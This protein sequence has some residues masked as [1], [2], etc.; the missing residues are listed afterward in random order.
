M[1]DPRLQRWVQEGEVEEWRARN[2]W[3]I[4]M[5]PHVHSKEQLVEILAKSPYLLL[6]STAM[7]TFIYAFQDYE[8]WKNFY[9]EPEEF[10][11][12]ITCC[13]D[14]VETQ[15]QFRNFLGIL[16]FSPSWLQSVTH[17]RLVLGDCDEEEDVESPP[18]NLYSL[19]LR[20]G[21]CGSYFDESVYL[22]IRELT[23]GRIEVLALP[24]VVLKIYY[25]CHS[26]IDVDEL[27]K[28]KN[29]QTLTIFNLYFT[30]LLFFRGGKQMLNETLDRLLTS[31][32]TLPHLISV[33]IE[34]ID[35]KLGAFQ[36]IIVTVEDLHAESASIPTDPTTYD[37]VYINAY[38]RNRLRREAT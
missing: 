11:K 21:S 35:G 31:L 29:L 14:F 33:T 22:Q 37:L 17:L 6:H 3:A 12:I 15:P 5:G 19:R 2:C 20:G 30:K 36:E 24:I 26:D 38:I 27:T 23:V 1:T 25:P 16:Q 8:A 10:N 4:G 28:Y 32:L 9:F 7:H 34:D 13:T 18:P